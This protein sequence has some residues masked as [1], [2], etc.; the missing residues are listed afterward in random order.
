MGKIFGQLI[1]N[2]PL[3]FRLDGHHGVSAD[4]VLQIF[5]QITCCY[6]SD[7]VKNSDLMWKQSVWSSV[8]ASHLAA[9]HLKEGG[10]LALTG[11]QPALEATPGTP[12]DDK[13]VAMAML[14]DAYNLVPSGMIGYGMAKAAVHQ[15]VKSLASTDA[16]LPK[17]AFV[18]AILP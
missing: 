7:L 3:W 17:D 11:A 14:T 2:L 6:V 1:C 10:V 16:G 5:A 9:L 15:L 12:L 13:V 8:I 4:E 18:S